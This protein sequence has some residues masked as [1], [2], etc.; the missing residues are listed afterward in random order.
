MQI[1]IGDIFES[2][3]ETIVNAVN[4]VGVMGWGY[5]KR[6]CAGIQEALSADVCRIC[7]AV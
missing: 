1:K 7:Q 3:A 4:C 5:G 2:Q 6:N